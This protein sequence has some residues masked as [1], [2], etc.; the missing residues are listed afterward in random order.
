MAIGMT[1]AAILVIAVINH[2]CAGSL[3]WCYT[4]FPDGLRRA[5][6][7]VGRVATNRKPEIS[8]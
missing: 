1:P 4:Q 7:D 6:A 3:G 2:S 5:K 8:S